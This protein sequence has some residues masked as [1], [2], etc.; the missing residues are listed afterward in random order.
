LA[1][2]KVVVDASAGVQASLTAGWG[3]L[4]GWQLVAPTLFWSEVAS[5]IRQL[6]YRREIS[7]AEA[8]DAISQLLDANIEAYPSRHLARDARHLARQLG[9]AKTY[10]AEFVALARRLGVGLLT[11]DARLAA[12]ARHL[13]DIY[14]P[15]D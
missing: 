4:D 13:V 3:A 10:D 7:A 8:S 6:E 14:P 2:D 12:T 9:W 1:T 5:G 15:S 11:V